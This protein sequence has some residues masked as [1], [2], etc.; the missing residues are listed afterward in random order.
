MILGGPLF[1]NIDL[2]SSR[3]FD[4]KYSLQAELI[5]YF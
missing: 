1:Q 4:N 3:D 5:Y 2:P